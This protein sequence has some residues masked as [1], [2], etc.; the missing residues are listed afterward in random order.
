MGAVYEGE[1]ERPRRIVALK[2]IKPELANR[3]TVWRF[4]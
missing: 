3:E 2:I 1:Q 4:D